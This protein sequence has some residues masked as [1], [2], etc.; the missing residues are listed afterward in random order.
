[1]DK[2]VTM[3][4]F[5]FLISGAYLL[6][7]AAVAAYILLVQ[8]L[9]KME[10]TLELMGYNAAKALHNPHT[11]E[12]DALLEKYALAFEKDDYE[13][14]DDELAKLQALCDEI[15]E[16]KSLTT[17]YRATAGIVSAMCRRK[18]IAHK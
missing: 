3:W 4:I 14:P 16:D 15:I 12:L 7:A 9:T 18:R 6:I 5:G 11:V 17:G 8:R 1:M 2:E 10:T 13:M